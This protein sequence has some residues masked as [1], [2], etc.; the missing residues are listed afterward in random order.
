M[1]SFHSGLAEW[2]CSVCCSWKFMEPLVTWI[3]PEMW[4][5]QGGPRLWNTKSRCKSPFL[6]K[7]QPEIAQSSSVMC[8]NLSCVPS[9]PFYNTWSVKK[10]QFSQ[11][12]FLPGKD[13]TN[14]PAFNHWFSYYFLVV[15][16]ADQP[17]LTLPSHLQLQTWLSRT[18]I[19]ICC[20]WFYYCGQFTPLPV[21]ITCPNCS[22]FECQVWILLV[23]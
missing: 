13:A 23:L 5:D 14:P 22:A 2:F 3:I 20:P 7:L 19:V 1:N 15:A 21:S 8:K 10:C 12:L 11:L 9:V 4:W 6:C 17:T 16:M 18:W